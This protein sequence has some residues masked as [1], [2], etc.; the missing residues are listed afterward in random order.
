M[1]TIC[2]NSNLQTAHCILLTEPEW[3]GEGVNEKGIIKAI[4]KDI[5]IFHRSRRS[6]AKT[7][8]SNIPVPT[9]CVVGDVIV[10]IDPK[11]FRPT[12]VELLIGNPS[13]AKEKLGWEAK[14]N[15]H[16]LVSK[17]IKSDLY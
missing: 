2:E 15:L 1:I 12:E 10:V 11:Y 13:K 3:K 16:E 7:E 4:K 8:H 17:M 5:P 6:E 9:N 14:T